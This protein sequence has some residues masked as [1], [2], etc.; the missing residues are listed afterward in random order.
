[1]I[2]RGLVVSADPA[3]LALAETLGAV[4][5]PEPALARLRSATEP[6]A[7]PAEDGEVALNAALDHA[8]AV[9][10]AAGATA[11]LALPADLPLLTPADVSALTAAL[12]PAPS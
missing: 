2:T 12:P 11:L 9:A 5:L 8:G 4:G 6:A 3:A 7:V 1:D 10:A